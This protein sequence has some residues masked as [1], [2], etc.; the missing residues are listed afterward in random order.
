MGKNILLVLFL[1]GRFSSLAQQANKLRVGTVFKDIS[2]YVNLSSTAVNLHYG[3]NYVK[4][5]ADNHYL[6]VSKFEDGHLGTN[7]YQMR[8]V[9]VTDIPPFRE[10][11]FS[12]K[13]KNCS[14][15]GHQD[16]ALFALVVSEDK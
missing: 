11:Y 3:V 10:E 13:L 14:L 1:M 9:E 15:N 7:D 5:F 8:V 4:T 6:V 12:I 16:P 2:G